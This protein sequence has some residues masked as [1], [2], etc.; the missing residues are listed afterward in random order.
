MPLSALLACIVGSWPL[1]S[2]GCGA[3]GWHHDARDVA[4]GWSPATRD[5]HLGEMI[6]NDRFVLLPGVQ[7]YG[8]ASQALTLWAACVAAD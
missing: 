2:I 7:I 8:L 6:T 3:A 4:I 1:R 5:T